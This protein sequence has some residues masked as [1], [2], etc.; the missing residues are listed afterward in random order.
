MHK[1]LS[2]LTA[3]V[4][5]LCI[6]AASA[7]PGAYSGLDCLTGPN[8]DTVCQTLG[9]PAKVVCTGSSSADEFYAVDYSGPYVWGTRD[10]E[11][12]CCDPTDLGTNIEP[13]KIHTYEDDD[14]VCAHTYGETD[15]PCEEFVGTVYTDLVWGDSAELYGGSGSDYLIA[16]KSGDDDEVEGGADSDVVFTYGGNDTITGGG[17]HDDLYAG[18]DN[19]W[20]EGGGGNDYISGYSGDDNLFG[21]DG[22][23]EIYADSGRDVVKGGDGADFLHVGNDTDADCVCTGFDNKSDTTGGGGGATIDTCYYKTGD[24]TNGVSTCLISVT[25][26]PPTAC[27]C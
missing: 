22:D 2:I 9:T 8:G 21:N 10:S 26:H 11:D 1:Y 14:L 19:D 24:D 13:L 15:T 17:G 23:D 7:C 3:A 4:A 16:S 12:F 18:E 6:G 25:T 20:V 27:G 5:Y